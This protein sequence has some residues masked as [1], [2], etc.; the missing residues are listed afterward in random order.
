M[1][2][3]LKSIAFISILFILLEIL[4]Y[5]FIPCTNIQKYGTFNASEYE[6]LGEKE[7]TI[8]VIALGDSLVYSSLSPMEIWDQFGYTVFDCAEA[9]QIIPNAYNYLKV[10]VES[11]HPKIVLMEAN[12][13]YRDPS[14]KN[15]RSKYAHKVNYFPIFLYHDNWKKYLS[16]GLKENWINNNKG[17]IHITK[18]KP[19]KNPV[20]LKPTNKSSE[21]LSSNLE[22]FEMIIDLCKN[23]DIKLV[24]VSFPT[25]TAW[26][27]KKHNGIVELTEK[28]NIDFIDLNLENLGINW[29]TD[30]KDEG[31][32][33]NYLG[34]KKV[35]L[36]L[37]NYL[38]DTELLKD[39]RNEEDYNLWNKALLKYRQ[40]FN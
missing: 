21:I 23:N 38:K 34:A 6:I 28:Y 14:K 37:G 10:A 32:H 5:Y 2:N 19:K 31:S 40:K 26:S 4:T 22:Y 15:W 17:Y 20:V 36:Y 25:Q 18:T 33:L 3:V 12:V 39:H 7:N 27:Y 11:Q 1:K 30:T 16:D 29:E 24:L 35:S 8:D 9:A 13:L